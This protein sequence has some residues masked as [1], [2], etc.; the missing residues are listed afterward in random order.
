V[1]VD[2]TRSRREYLTR[3][4]E[5]DIALDTWPFN[6]ITTT[7]DG[8]WMG[9]PCVTLAGVTSVSKA[10]TSILN[11]ANL[12]E[13]CAESAGEFVSI[14]SELAKNLDRLSELR[15]TMRDRLLASPL[16][17]HRAFARKLEAEYRRMWADWCL[18]KR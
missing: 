9:V 7:C 6:G 5:I 16:F 14:T 15:N 11:A 17:D 4:D 1:I 13:L 2:K 18:S 12:A 8:L 10:G 3:F